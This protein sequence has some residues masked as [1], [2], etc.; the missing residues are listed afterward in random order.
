MPVDHEQYPTATAAPVVPAALTV[1]VRH[2]GAE[3]A[4]CAVAGDLDIDSLSPA[5]EALASLV[6]QRPA[7]VVV[8]LEAVGFCDSSGLNLLL[9]TRLA[10]DAAGV[11]FRLAAIAPPVARVLELTGAGAVFSIHES[12][13]AALAA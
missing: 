4:V 6:K 3:A 12:V 8:D 9:K 13:G 11:G 1:E 10:A 2:T 5:E 7:L